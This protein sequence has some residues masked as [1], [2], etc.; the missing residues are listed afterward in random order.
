MEAVIIIDMMRRAGVDVTVAGDGHLITCSKG[1]RIVPDTAIDDLGEY[2]DFDIII[3]PGGRQGV[4]NFLAN[5]SLRQLIVKHRNAK[6]PLA[7]I[8]AAPF[9]LH[10]L[11][12]LKSGSKV[13]SHPTLEHEFTG[14][15]YVTDRVVDENGIITSR[16]AGTA[17]EFALAIIKKYVDEGTARWLSTDIVLY[18]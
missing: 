6:R 8:C 1:V 7:A 16:G 2:D 4:Q 13:T 9:V 15:N 17:F 5:E 11:E 14:Y 12:L 3:L 18:E 10:E